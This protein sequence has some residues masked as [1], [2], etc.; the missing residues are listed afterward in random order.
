MKS[1]PYL[2][3]YPDEWIMDQKIKG[4][5]WNIIPLKE[6]IGENFGCISASKNT[7]KLKSNKQN[8]QKDTWDNAKLKFS[9]TVKRPLGEN[10]CKLHIS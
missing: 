6:N 9:H 3:P 1:D 2:T 7:E 4:N 8:K 5:M 10:L